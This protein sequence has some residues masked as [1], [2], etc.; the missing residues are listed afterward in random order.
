IPLEWIEVESSTGIEEFIK[1]RASALQGSLDITKGPVVRFAYFKIKGA[2]SGYLLIISHHLVIDG[3]SWRILINDLELVCTGSPDLPP[4][5]TSFKQYSEYLNDYIINEEELLPY[6]NTFQNEEQGTEFPGASKDKGKNT[7]ESLECISTALSGEETEELVTETTKTF[8]TNI[9]DILAAALAETFFSFSGNRTLLIDMESHGRDK[10]DTEIDVSG[11]IGW[12]TSIYPVLL[13][14]RASQSLGDSIKTVKEQ[15]RLS[16]KNCLAYGILK[17]NKHDSEAKRLILKNPKADIL[18]NYL[19]QFDSTFSEESLF[20]TADIPIGNTQSSKQRRSHLLEINSHIIGGKLYVNWNYSRNIY[21][22]S[23]AQDIAQRFMDILRKLMEYCRTEQGGFT[24]SDFPLTELTQE[25]IDSLLCKYTDIEDVYPLSAMQQVVLSHNLYSRKSGTDIQLITWN[26]EGSLDLKMFKEA[27]QQVISSHPILRT[28]FIW[29]KLKQPVQVVHC[30]ANPEFLYIDLSTK[31]ADY[32]EEE[33]DRIVQEWGRKSFNVEESTLMR[34]CII[35]LGENSFKFIWVYWT[36]LFDNWSWTRIVS[37]VL[38]YYRTYVKG[39]Q[40]TG[41]NS[42]PFKEY[43]K[44]VLGQDEDEEK[45]FWIEELK[46]F[47]AKMDMNID[48]KSSELISSAFEP[49]QEEIRLSGEETEKINT[50]AKNHGLTLGSIVQGAWVLTLGFFTDEQDILFSVLS[51]GRPA[52]L[53]GVDTIVGLLANDLPLRVKIKKEAYAV[54]W[55]GDIQKKN[56]TVRQYDYVPIEQIIKW[57]KIPF[58]TIQKA[59]YE[60]N[61]IFS[62][63]PEDEMLS[64]QSADEDI[65]FNGFN[66][67]LKFNVPLRVYV[68]PDDRI[69]IRIKYNKAVFG[70]DAITRILDKIYEYVMKL[71]DKQKSKINELL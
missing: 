8:H 24:P 29:R 38:T 7:V 43:I 20:E 54:E 46:A 57:S 33:A 69:T 49:G 28:S 34:F 65:K 64:K 63:A 36:S 21:K 39:T 48:R 1:N 42:V 70:Q 53:N 52:S 59:I 51:Y 27:W 10:V 58:S 47:N 50:Y 45:R 60:R 17:Y 56:V 22:E 67:S 6:L 71:T 12:F 62:R 40:I 61:L 26:I 37:E 44:W 18:F 16:A 19:G 14:I 31:S 4:K 3:V 32:Q 5:T 2:G 9:N 23:L 68:E 30:S 55:L 35:K 15:L 41:R 25:K 11:T 66:N 13:D